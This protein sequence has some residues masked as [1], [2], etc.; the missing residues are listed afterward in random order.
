MGVPIIVSRY[1]TMSTVEIV[2]GFFGRS[3][4]QQEKKTQCFQELLSE[5]FDFTSLYVALGL[6]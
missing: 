3:R 2:E 1:D 6:N 4:F 5:H